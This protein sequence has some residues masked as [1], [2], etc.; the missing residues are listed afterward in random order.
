MS[1]YTTRP[2]HLLDVGDVVLVTPEPGK[3]RRP[4]IMNHRAAE[5]VVKSMTYTINH[6]VHVWFT[7]GDDMIVHPDTIVKVKV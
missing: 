7:T 5:V 3:H 1:V 4:S 6:N 2:A